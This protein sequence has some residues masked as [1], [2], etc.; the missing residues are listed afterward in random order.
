MPKSLEEAIEA[1]QSYRSKNDAGDRRYS[2]CR[3]C[4]LNIIKVSINYF[5][6]HSQLGGVV[7]IGKEGLVYEWHQNWAGQVR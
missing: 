1:S 4:I 6:S 3:Q 2:L 7:L 5:V